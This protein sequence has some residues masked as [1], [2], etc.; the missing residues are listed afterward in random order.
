MSLCTVLA[1]VRHAFGMFV[2]VATSTFR[3]VVRG[4]EGKQLVAMSDSLWQPRQCKNTCPICSVPL[5]QAYSEASPR[6][7]C[8]CLLHKFAV[9]T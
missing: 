1:L 5:S 4:P 2:L 6:V 8:R 9:W 3:S 7:M